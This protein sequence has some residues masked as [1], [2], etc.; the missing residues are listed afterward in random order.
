MKV[1]P[2]LLPYSL[3]TYFYCFTVKPFSNIDP[4][5]TEVFNLELVVQAPCEPSHYKY[6]LHAL[7]GASS[8]CVV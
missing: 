6:N 7:V 1:Q 2:A 8:Q 5:G 4:I 3:I